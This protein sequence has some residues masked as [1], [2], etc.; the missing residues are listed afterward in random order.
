MTTGHAVRFAMLGET[1]IAAR[2]GRLVDEW[3]GMA[4]M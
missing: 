3:L 2:T 1:Q 4:Y